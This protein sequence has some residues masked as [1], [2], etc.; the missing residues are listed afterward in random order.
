MR[1]NSWLQLKLAEVWEK[2]FSDVKKLNTVEIHF[3]KKAKRRLASIRQKRRD[4][5]HSDTEIRVTSH[6][7]DERV[8]EYVV[9]TTIAHELC[10][11]TH[12]FA[13][14][15]PQYFSH[16]H[17]GDVVDNELKKRG[18]GQQ[19]KM[20]EEWLKS[21]WIKIVGEDIFAKRTRITRRRRR[22]Q[23]NVGNSLLRFIRGLGYN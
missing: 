21:D 2:Y 4:N 5:K 12:G 18:L 14:P 3:G 6:Y 13:S 22:K 19:L 16:P 1:D 15:H 7:Q 8:P 11:Y 9:T 20:Q 10:H 23:V 17:R